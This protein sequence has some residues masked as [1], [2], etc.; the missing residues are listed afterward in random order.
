MRALPLT[1]ASVLVLVVA[2]PALAVHLPPSPNDADDL[3]TRA[4]GVALGTALP[5]TCAI[6]LSPLLGQQGLNCGS[7]E[8]LQEGYTCD[9]AD[10]GERCVVTL[11]A[12][13]IASRWIQDGGMTLSLRS[14]FCSTDD[15]QEWVAGTLAPV[16]A[17]ATCS[18]ALQ[19]QPGEC[20]RG[21][22]RAQLVFRG[23][24]SPAA[25]ASDGDELDVGAC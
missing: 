2:G 10:G 5:S 19:L 9:G 3:A 11:S 13:G 4:E 7:L 14:D 25:L 24:V 12:Q 16:E 6:A 8:F 18:R 20:V 17:Y 22:V 21:V 1:V 23:G 15:D